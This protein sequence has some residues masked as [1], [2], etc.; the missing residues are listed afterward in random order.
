MQRIPVSAP[1]PPLS[2]AAASRG[3]GSAFM[4]IDEEIDGRLPSR[5]HALEWPA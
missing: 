4:A 3:R 1:L 2:P 5:L